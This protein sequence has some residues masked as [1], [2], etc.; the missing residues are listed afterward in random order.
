M[1]RQHALIA[2][3]TSPRNHARTRERSSESG[4]VH[5]WRGLREGRKVVGST[6]FFLEKR[7]GLTDSGGS[8]AWG[9]NRAWPTSSRDGERPGGLAR[10]KEDNES[11]HP[12]MVLD[13]LLTG[14][15]ITPNALLWASTDSFCGA[16]EKFRWA[17]NGPYPSSVTSKP[18]RYPQ[19]A[20]LFRLRSVFKTTASAVALLKRISFLIHGGS[21]CAHDTL[22][23][24][25]SRRRRCS[26]AWPPEELGGRGVAAPWS[27]RQQAPGFAA[28]AQRDPQPQ[29]GARL[30]VRHRRRLVAHP[31]Q[32]SIFRRL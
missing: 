16:H 5:A 30:A 22:H 32:A 17:L 11:R 2:S 13:G 9:R 10:S 4:V 24:P 20:A 12:C 6:P 29:A 25:P 28:G 31:C 23:R 26:C 1:G 19:S 8:F 21:S 15:T 7:V 3:T 27:A 18:S 14:L